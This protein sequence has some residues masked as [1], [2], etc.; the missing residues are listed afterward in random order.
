MENLWDWG[1]SSTDPSRT[2][3]TML[4][5]KNKVLCLSNN[6]IQV[7]KKKESKSQAS[8]KN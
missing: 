7:N 4:K 2:T 8:H 1:F 3:E 6:Q 5:G